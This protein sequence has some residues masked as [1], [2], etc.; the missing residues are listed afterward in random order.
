M[1][2]SPC[3]TESTFP[4]W[5]HI[6]VTPMHPPPPLSQPYLNLF[7]HDSFIPSHGSIHPHCFKRNA[8]NPNKP[9]HLDLLV[10]DSEEVGDSRGA[11]SAAG[12]G[13]GLSLRTPV[14]GWLGPWND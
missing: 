9:T 10:H 13:L 12:A 1:P 6:K 4:T 11:Q 5:K 14:A 3:T 2:H 7:T 8:P